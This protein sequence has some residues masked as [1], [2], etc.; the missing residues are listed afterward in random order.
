MFLVRYTYTYIYRFLLLYTYM[1]TGSLY[2]V[3]YGYR[4]LVLYSCMD[5]G[6]LYSIHIWIQVPCILYIYGYRFPCALYMYGYTGSLYSKH[7]WI[8]VL[9]L[10]IHKYTL[11]ASH[12]P[13]KLWVAANRACY[14]NWHGFYSPGGFYGTERNLSYSMYVWP[15]NW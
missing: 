9:N 14:S 11:G 5:T 3:H 13:P 7:I 15:L 1:D 12:A 10:N 4:F 8:Q 6:F 2:S